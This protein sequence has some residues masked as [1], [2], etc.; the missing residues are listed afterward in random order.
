MAFPEVIAQAQR[1][2]AVKTAIDLAT[3][4]ASSGNAGVNADSMTL[5]LNNTYDA[6]L[7]L[8]AKATMVPDQA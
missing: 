6:I 7:E 1:A 3:A 5:F 4:W 8:T 2:R